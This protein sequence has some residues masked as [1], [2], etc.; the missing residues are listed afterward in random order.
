METERDLIP[1][2]LIAQSGP[3][4]K[5]IMNGSPDDKLEICVKLFMSTDR[6]TYRGMTRVTN[7]EVTQSV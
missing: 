5:L 7:R 6:R 3:A 2:R 4:L 1:I